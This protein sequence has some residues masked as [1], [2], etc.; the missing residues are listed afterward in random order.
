RHALIVGRPEEA[1]AHLLK[2]WTLLGRLTRA[3][4]PAASLQRML[5]LTT[6]FLG[7]ASLMRDDLAAARVWYDR[8]MKEFEGMASG[9]D[10]LERRGE[11]GSCYAERGMFEEAT[12]EP[13]EALAWYEKA[14]NTLEGLRSEERVDPSA[15]FFDLLPTL[16]QRIGECRA[17]LAE[18]QT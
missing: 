14:L 7:R 8:S 4:H 18:I 1:E 13:A 6:Y 9:A 10:N 16:R 11:G 5:A 12:L 2:G 3:D 15:W 17:V